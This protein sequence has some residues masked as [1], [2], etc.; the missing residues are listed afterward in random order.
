MVYSNQWIDRTKQLLYGIYSI[1][2][3]PPTLC[4]LPPIPH[5]P[6]NIS[7]E[8]SITDLVTEQQALIAP[9]L[10][11]PTV[12]ATHSSAPLHS[13]LCEA[14]QSSNTTPHDPEQ[15]KEN[16]AGTERYST[17]TIHIHWSA[18][19]PFGVPA[20]TTLR[21]WAKIDH[22]TWKQTEIEYNSEM[23]WSLKVRKETTSPPPTNLF[24][25]R[26]IRN[27]VLWI[28]P[29]H[30]SR[31][32]TRLLCSCVCPVAFLFSLTRAS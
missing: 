11:Q 9:L 10:L 18:M 5:P 15:Q 7:H 13:P 17:Q 4:P 32:A 8:H 29:S 28:V 20:T 30:S 24:Y 3:L 14:N 12:Q 26:S 2:P 19:T 22:F 31:S 21:Y 27:R 25:E 1:D 16:R 23:I 6:S